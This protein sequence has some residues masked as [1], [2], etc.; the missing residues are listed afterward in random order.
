MHVNPLYQK[1]L[2]SALMDTNHTVRLT[3][4][5]HIPLHKRKLGLRALGFALLSFSLLALWSYY[6]TTA[7]QWVWGTVALVL[8]VGCLIASVI[9]A[10]GFV[11]KLLE[12]APGLSVSRMGLRDNSTFYS[13]G[14]MPWENIQSVHVVRQGSKHLLAVK[15]KHPQKYIARLNGR[16][17]KVADKRMELY[18]TPYLVRMDYLDCNIDEVYTLIH[19]QINQHSHLFND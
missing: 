10:F 17:Q 2:S 11:F 18:Q 13:C 15:I 3:T 5:V 14:F 1:L 7:L 19:H 4:E 16:A 9:Y 8:F 12:Q 6:D